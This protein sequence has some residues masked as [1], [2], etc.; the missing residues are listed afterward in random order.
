MGNLFSKS[1]DDDKNLETFSLIWLDAEVNIKT[2]NIK[3][4]EELRESM[5]QLKTYEYAEPCQN[6]IKSLSDKD[7][8]IF[9]CSGSLGEKV[10]PNIHHLRQ[11]YSIY[12]F[13]LNDERHRQWSREYIKVTGAILCF[14]NFILFCPLGSRCFYT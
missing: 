10:V 6:D 13:C 7:R 4:Q 11:V 14:K 1:C 2:Y 3:A 12:I 8:I 5:N 9:L